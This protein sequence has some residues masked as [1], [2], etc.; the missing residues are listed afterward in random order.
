M[1]ILLEPEDVKVLKSS[2][3]TTDDLGTKDEC[4]SKA[5]KPW[6]E[7]TYKDP[8]DRLFHDHLLNIHI[9]VDREYRKDWASGAGL[10][11]IKGPDGKD[12]FAVLHLN[13]RPRG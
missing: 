13:N 7:P 5:A 6:V 11:M 10:N 9:K 1:E 4:V 3:N 2:I 12:K 8:Q